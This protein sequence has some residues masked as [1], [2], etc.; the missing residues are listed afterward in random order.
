MSASYASL[1][2]GP[3]RVDG[4]T[5]LLRPPRFDDFDA[6]R[7]LRLRDR[8]ELEPFWFSSPLTWDQRHSRAQW[9][10][11]CL[12]AASE[13]AAGRRIGTVLEID[14]QFAGQIELVGIDPRTRAA[15]LSVW[16]D[17]EVGRR[18]VTGLAGAMLLDFAFAEAS[19][20]RVTAPVAVTNVDARRA[21]RKYWARE[22]VLTRY[23]DVGG[24]RIDHELWALTRDRLPEGGL[25]AELLAAHPGATRTSVPAPAPVRGRPI[26]RT[27]VLC[28]RARQLLGRVR[29]LAD[30]LRG[31]RP[32]SVYDDKQH[33]TVRSWRP[34][35]F[36]H[37][38]EHP[39]AGTALPT[40]SS[41][42][43][44]RRRRT[45]RAWWCGALASRAGLRSSHG[46]VF[47]VEHEGRRVGTCRLFDQDMFD[48]NVRAAVAI[49]PA[50]DPAIAATAL[51]ML[52]AHATEQLGIWRVAL[53]VPTSDR[54]GAAVAMSAGLHHE[55]TLHRFRGS[56]GTFTDH[57]LWAFSTAPD[58]VTADTGGALP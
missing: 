57:D 42:A 44:A 40:T 25:V 7:R 31:S 20:E 16:V 55:G 22:A 56:D 18:G 28:V 39:T 12:A 29:H 43:A 50:T 11:E 3:V 10:R 36:L 51:R 35:D 46:L 49:S 15:E 48:R 52:I 9:V 24:R 41:V 53:T 21:V 37:D 58:H 14:G 8:D 47:T 34:R 13:A 6:W 26:P 38:T 54:T 32:I 1:R 23:F 33:V 4:V 30:P 2:L 19:L 5:A 45:P 17:A 27:T